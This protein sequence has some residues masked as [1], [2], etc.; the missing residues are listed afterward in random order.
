MNGQK[1]LNY[2]YNFF[3]DLGHKFIIVDDINAKSTQ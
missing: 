3:N 1:F 2:N